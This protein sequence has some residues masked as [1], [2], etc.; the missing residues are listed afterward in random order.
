ML[1][2]DVVLEVLMEECTE[3]SLEANRLSK[4]A[5]KAIRFGMPSV[6]NANTQSPTPEGRLSNA[7]LM[8]EAIDNLHDEIIDVQ[9]L[10][11]LVTYM[12]DGREAAKGYI[13]RYL[14]SALTRGAVSAKLMKCSR[15]ARTLIPKGSI[16]RDTYVLLD[17]AISEANQL[18]LPVTPPVPASST[19][20]TA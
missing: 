13:A 20:A 11:Y 4:A 5:S 16:T 12:Y 19:T 17:D 6:R 7:Q 3:V 15:H 9:A 14:P 18:L 1:A 10:H 2:L 8:R